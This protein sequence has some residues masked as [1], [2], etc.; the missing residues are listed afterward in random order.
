MLQRVWVLDGV[1]AQEGGA[2]QSASSEAAS[3]MSARTLVCENASGWSESVLY[4]GG[5]CLPHYSMVLWPLVGKDGVGRS[6]MVVENPKPSG[7]RGSTVEQELRERV[8]AWVSC[9]SWC[10]C[11]GR[12]RGPALFESALTGDVRRGLSA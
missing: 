6:G 10:R 5:A 4:F 11:G 9:L 2:V 1:Y 8:W 12:G 7:A 3:G